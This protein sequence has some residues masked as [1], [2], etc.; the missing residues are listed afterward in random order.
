MSEVSSVGG[1]AFFNHMMLFT[2]TI[3]GQGNL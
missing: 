3:A 1:S 2:G